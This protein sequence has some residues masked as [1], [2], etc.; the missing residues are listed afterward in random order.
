L[1]VL[2]VKQAENKQESFFYWRV[3]DCIHQKLSQIVSEATIKHIASW[4]RNM[5]LNSFL[6]VEE[7]LSIINKMY[8][9]LNCHHMTQ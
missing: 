3:E 7:V 2:N 6:E 1:T 8:N 9:D 5:F 4:M